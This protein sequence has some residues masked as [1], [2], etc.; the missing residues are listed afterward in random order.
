MKLSNF[1]PFPG[2]PPQKNKL[3]AEQSYFWDVLHQIEVP[4]IY[5]LQKINCI[6]NT[7]KFWN[8]FSRLG[9][10]KTVSFFPLLLYSLG[11]PDQAKTLAKS[12]IFYGLFSSFGKLVMKR[13]RPGSFPE[14]FALGCSKSSS[15]PS[16]HVI[17]TTIIAHFIPLEIP[18]IIMMILSRILLGLHYPT[19]CFVGFFFGRFCLFCSQFV[20]DKNLILFLLLLDMRLWRSAGKICA[21]VLP[22]IMAPNIS[23]SKYCSPL[24]LFYF[25]FKKLILDKTIEKKSLK[26]T[27][28]LLASY[29]LTVFIIVKSNEFI[30]LS[31]IKN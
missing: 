26:E 9:K 14:V 15:F 16:R 20:N 1:P 5:Y 22:I 10:S 8:Y 24:F 7:V 31:N 12:L 29:C 25:L 19:D 27:M 30:E 4:F 17:G 3:I 6:T 23:V 28:R 2:K 21:G 13:R 18:L 11:F